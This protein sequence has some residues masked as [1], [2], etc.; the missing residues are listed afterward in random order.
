MIEG[1]AGLK[2]DQFPKTEQDERC[3]FCVY[4]SLCDRGQRAG[5]WDQVDQGLDAELDEGEVFEFDIDFD[6]IAE[7]EF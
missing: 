5:D 6:Q 1:I 3:R 4:R 7:V 2:E